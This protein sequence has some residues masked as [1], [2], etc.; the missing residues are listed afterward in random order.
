MRTRTHTHEPLPLEWGWALREVAV[1][2][3]APGAELCEAPP[4]SC[5]SSSSRGI[6]CSY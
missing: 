6:L 5:E 1:P 3:S 4:V 2:L